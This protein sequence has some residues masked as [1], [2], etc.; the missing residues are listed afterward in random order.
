MRQHKI[1]QDGRHKRISTA[2]EET[3]DPELKAAAPSELRAKN[4][5]LGEDEKEY[6]DSYAQSSKRARIP[7]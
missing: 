1:S 3:V 5:V 2:S 6:A 4:F 7:P